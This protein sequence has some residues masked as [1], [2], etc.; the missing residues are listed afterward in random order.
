MEKTG[1]SVPSLPSSV[2]G[3]N[4]FAPSSSSALTSLLTSTSS[5]SAKGTTETAFASSGKGVG[6]QSSGSRTRHRLIDEAS[7]VADLP[8]P[9]PGSEVAE[10]PL[11]GRG[12]GV[13]EPH[14]SEQQVPVIPMTARAASTREELGD[15]EWLVRRWARSDGGESQCS[16]ESQLRRF[17][18]I[19]KLKAEKRRVQK[20]Q[21]ALVEELDRLVK[22]DEMSR[23]GHSSSASSEASFSGVEKTSEPGVVHL[24]D[25]KGIGNVRELDSLRERAHR[26]EGIP[27]GVPIY[28]KIGVAYAAPARH[29]ST[30]YPAGPG[31]AV[32]SG[33]VAS[34]DVADSSMQPSSSSFP[35]VTTSGSAGSWNVVPH[36]SRPAVDPPQSSGPIGVGPSVQV[37]N[38]QNI[39]ADNR[40][41]DIHVDSVRNVYEDN[42]TLVQNTLVQ[43]SAQTV[44][45]VTQL[46]QAHV[47]HV[48]GVAGAHVAG[49]QQAANQEVSAALSAAEA[50]VQ[51]YQAQHSELSAAA[52]Q[53][54]L[55]LEEEAR[56]QIEEA[57]QQAEAQGQRAEAEAQR[58]AGIA[59][60]LAQ[61]E[62]KYNELISL[63][64]I[65]EQERNAAQHAA[66]EEAAQSL[67]A[68]ARV[69]EA[70]ERLEHERVLRKRQEEAAADL[71]A[72]HENYRQQVNMAMA[73][74]PVP[75]PM[76]DAHHL[77]GHP[78]PFSPTP[79]TPTAPNGAQG[80]TSAGAGSRAASAAAVGAR[81]GPAA[82]TVGESSPEVAELPQAGEQAAGAAELPAGGSTVHRG[83]AELSRTGKSEQVVLS[84]TRTVTITAV[85]P[86]T[87]SQPHHPSGGPPEGGGDDWPG[88]GRPLGGGYGGASGSKG[89]PGGGDDPPNDDDGDDP[90]KPRSPKDKKKKKKS[91][92]GGGSSLD[93]DEPS[94]PSSDSEA[95]R[96][97]RKAI[98]RLLKEQ[99]FKVAETVLVPKLPLTPQFRSWKNAVY[100]NINSASGRNDDEALTWAMQAELLT[101]VP[102]EQLEDSGRQYY[103]LDVRLSAAIQKVATGELGRLISLA[104]ERAIKSGRSIKGRELLRMIIQY[105]KTNARAETVYNINDLQAVTMH[106]DGYKSLENF[107]NWWQAVIQSIDDMPTDTI[108]EHVYYKKIKHSKCIAED[109]A[110]YNRLEEGS[111]GDR[112]YQFLRGAVDRYLK[113]ERQEKN[114]DELTKSVQRGVFSD[115]NAAPGRKAKGKGKGKDRPDVGG[116]PGAAAAPAENKRR[117]RSRKK[118]SAG[119]KSSRKSSM[120]SGR[121]SG[122]SAAGTSRSPSRKPKALVLCPFHAKGFCKK[123]AQCDMSHGTAAPARGRSVTNS[124]SPGGTRRKS[125]SFGGT[126]RFSRSPGGKFRRRRKSKSPRG[127]GDGG[128]RAICQL[129]QVGRCSFGKRCRHRHSS[130]STSSSRRKHARG[131][132]KKK[133]KKVKRKRFG[134]SMLS[135]LTLLPRLAAASIFEGL[136]KVNFFRDGVSSEGKACASRA[137]LV[138][139]LPS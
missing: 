41:V 63:G 72:I 115:A 57:A 67:A 123:G 71:R 31:V 11:T 122:T 121:S 92:K 132:V 104:A 99:K 48:Q 2:D 83:I 33:Q 23:K 131:Y 12:R 42:R 87:A 65:V 103:L 6:G 60:E 30:A 14:S 39:C 136:S 109:L 86:K 36:A 32:P 62:E 59:G 75:A 79:A 113:R 51:M 37:Q 9:E 35:T 137:A 126:K 19:K 106:G 82:A 44:S 58:A 77:S 49:V 38:Q 119:R 116:T 28:G 25:L 133:K 29:A 101:T 52:R 66:A 90:H 50:A 21:D 118:S 45:L 94:S 74:P 84:G 127:R 4:V 56:R 73:C 17:E 88:G 128:G 68:A 24:A 110:H 80:G 47:N 18:A 102:D 10:L 93:P 16:T 54:V 1:T 96:R 139:E 61:K 138:A 55:G 129:W 7:V 114:R 13:V 70:E 135:A 20:E 34:S 100:Q 64:Y 3:C 81:A 91:R 40:V 134:W 130:R 120:S 69:R 98:R 89:P 107:Q 76:M 125:R 112:C 124:R 108:L 111:G 8:L 117:G 105:Y 78:S 15:Y 22:E 43:D 85:Q 46:A 97:E 27:E 95:E 26:L 53:Y 5:P